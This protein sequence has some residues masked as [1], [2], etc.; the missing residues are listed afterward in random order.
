ERAAPLRLAALG[1]ADDSSHLYQRILAM[2]SPTPRFVYGRALVA[3]AVAVT[4]V[5]A[6]C[7][8]TMPTQA[9]VQSMDAASAERAL[10][11]LKAQAD[12][13]AVTYVVDGRAKTAAK[14]ASSARIR[15]RRSS[16]CGA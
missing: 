5:L 16:S 4:A 7:E 14:R 11:A 9:D 15:S 3:A 13:A 8:S 12:S 1:L 2:K 6:A 10:V